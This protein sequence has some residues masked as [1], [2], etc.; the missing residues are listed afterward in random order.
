[1]ISA[2]V[3]T[4]AGVNGLLRLH[5]EVVLQEGSSLRQAFARKEATP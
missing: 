3:E 1:M 4:A 2:T 5:R